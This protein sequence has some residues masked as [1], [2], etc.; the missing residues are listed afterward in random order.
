VTAVARRAGVLA[1]SL[2][3]L[4]SPIRSF[5]AG[6]QLRVALSRRSPAHGRQPLRALPAAGP[7]RHRRP[8]AALSPLDGAPRR[9]S[10]TTSPTRSSNDDKAATVTAFV[11]RALAYFAEHGIACKRLMTDNG[12][13]YVKNRSL[14]E[15]LARHAIRHV[16]TQ[17]YRPRTNGKVEAL[18]PDDG[19]TMDL[20]PRLT[21]PVD[22]ARPRCHTGS[23]GTTGNGHKAQSATG[24][25]SAPFTTSVGRTASTG[26]RREWLW[27]PRALP[28]CRAAAARDR[29]PHAF[30]PPALLAGP[31]HWSCLRQACHSIVES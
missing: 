15:L 13:S 16:T 3:R 17:P 29:A 6:Q 14:R 28:L 10:T 20:R 23:T 9:G 5:G 12:F 11:E 26:R 18:P 24:H 30:H 8:L 22:T 21:A 25:R 19:P 1:W 27:L 4:A 7:P 2:G 31:P